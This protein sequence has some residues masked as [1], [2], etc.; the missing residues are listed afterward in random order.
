[1]ASTDPLVINIDVET[2]AG[3]AVSYSTLAPKYSPTFTGTVTATGATAVNLPA[4]TSIG[5]ITPTNIFAL[6]GAT[7]NI[8]AQLNAINLT[9]PTGDILLP[10]KSGLPASL[11]FEGGSDDAYESTITPQ[12]PVQDFT[13]YLPAPAAS[14]F[15]IIGS[16]SQFH[17]V[18]EGDNLIHTLSNK[19]LASP[20]FTGTA[21]A[22][23]LTVTGTLFV[24]GTTTVINSSTLNVD[25]KN[26]ELGAVDVPTNSTANG[27]GI[28][29]KGTTDKTIIWDSANSNWTSSE[30]F[31]LPTGKVFKINNVSVLSATQILG[32][33]VGG[34]SA[35]DIATIDATQTLRN[36]TFDSTST[37]PGMIVTSATAPSTSMIWADPNDATYVTLIDGGSA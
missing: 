1:M 10:S 23:D 24:S 29:L 31:N 7:N 36:K 12:D 5:T 32:K 4:E 20:I 19:T 3:A 22:N 34:T 13:F 16:T 8:Q 33:T 27:G 2:S 15:A 35:G 30:N 14:T 37:I 11:I 9:L 18:F 17:T 26:I 6:S 21:Q 25:D 28:T